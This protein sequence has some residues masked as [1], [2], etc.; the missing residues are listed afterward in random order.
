M[1]LGALQYARSSPFRVYGYS[2]LNVLGPVFLPLPCQSMVD[3]RTA[4]ILEKTLGFSSLH[5]H[6][7]R[8]T[9][10]LPENGEALRQ[11]FNPCT[12]HPASFVISPTRLVLAA[13]GVS[14]SSC[15]SSVLI[16]QL[17]GGASLLGA[18]PCQPPSCPCDTLHPNIHGPK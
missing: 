11:G 10:F 8:V 16:T 7:R 5:Q 9:R 15:T 13:T 12:L 17:R 6:Y 18:S 14:M 4:S 1:S 3:S 2:V